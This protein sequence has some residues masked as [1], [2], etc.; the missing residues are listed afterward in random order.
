MSAQPDQKQRE[1]ILG[2]CLMSAFADG[3][4]ADAEREEIHGIA[5]TLGGA[6]A[7]NSA[8]LHDVLFKRVTLDSL[9]VP[10]K[11]QTFAP[12]VYEMAAAVCAADKNPA[13]EERAFLEELRTQLGLDSAEIAGTAGIM[14]PAPSMLAAETAAAEKAAPADTERMVLN[15][16]ILN[17]ALELFPQSLAT[18]AVIPMQLKMVY[19]IGQSHG[20]EL[21]TAR[22]KELAAAAGLGLTSQVLEG[23]ARRL[24]K[25]VLGKKSMAGSVT[26]QA[27]SSAFAFASTYAL[28]HV[29]RAYY[30]GGRQM[31]KEQMKSLFD[32][33]SGR[34]RGL[35]ESY[36]PQI[37]D[38]AKGLD[39]PKILAEIKSPAPS[40]GA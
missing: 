7:D 22:I 26:G 20:I 27:T 29:A 5:T 1:S 3:S 8:T 18:M 10:L 14:N 15:Y 4:H 34:A 39:L 38:K 21:D 40:A 17:G 6:E 35:Y 28:G 12:Q 19:R 25:G 11:G 23:Y 36:L 13:P 37:Q 24:L 30:D 16:A 9:C 32:S 2:I 33:V 31:T